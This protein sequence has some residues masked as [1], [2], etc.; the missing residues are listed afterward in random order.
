[1]LR[2]LCRELLD[3]H[4][5]KQKVVSLVF[6]SF[7]LNI[8]FVFRFV[9]YLVIADEILTKHISRIVCRFKK[10]KS[11]GEEKLDGKHKTTDKVV[12]DLQAKTNQSLKKFLNII[13]FFIL[14][15]SPRPIC[16]KVLKKKN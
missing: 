14:F 10:T 16:Q 11:V 1:M 4:V 15:D 2:L 6:V 9:I 3:K 13:L 5:L 7:L 12:L 8:N